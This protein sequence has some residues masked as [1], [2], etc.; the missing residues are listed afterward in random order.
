MDIRKKEMKNGLVVA[1][2]VMPHL[3]S[4]SLGVW[5]KCGSRIE[6]A[7]NTGISHFIEHLVF[8]GTRKRTAAKIAEVTDSIGGH[9]NAFTEKEYVGFYAKV[10]DEHLPI[11]FDLV[12]DIVL[13]PIFPSVEIKRERN[14][15]FEEI[16]MVEDSPQ[17]L[18]MDL[19]MD[20][21]WKEHALGRPISGTKAS[22]AQI[23]R[24]DVKKFFRSY[25][26]A[27]NML[28]SVAGNIRHQETFKLAERYFSHLQPGAEAAPGPPPSVHA[29]RLI[30]Q[31]AH[32]EQTH[33][34]LGTVSPSMAS[35]DRYCA[36]LLSNILGGGMSSRLFQNIRERRGLVYSIY[37]MLNLYRDA[38]TLVVYAGAAPEKASEV[39]NL[40]LKEFRGLRNSLVSAQELKRAKEYIKGSV[41]LS[42][43]SSSSRMTNLA[44]QLIYHDRFVKLEEILDAVNRVSAR[45]IRH[46]ANKMFDSTTLALT[47]LSGRNGRDLNAVA[48]QV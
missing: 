32:L 25:Y 8:K 16:N 41:L 1:T 23:T 33:I 31:K 43:E 21:F 46:L 6:N 26:N 17:E 19:Y 14:V 2:E 7:K 15:I 10:M 28:V 37:S 40:I 22:V 47:A 44:Q 3:R 34:C 20:S 45:D 39:V 9:L 48:I 35:E 4:V 13:N 29:D 38:G 5:I 27:S 30:R 12:S 36:H 18:I 42:L 11:A 24:N